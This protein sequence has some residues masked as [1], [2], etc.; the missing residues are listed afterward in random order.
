METTAL[1]DHLLTSIII[2]AMAANLKPKVKQ[3]QEH[4]IIGGEQKKHVKIKM[5]PT[6][7]KESSYVMPAKN[8]ITPVT[9][10]EKITKPKEPPIKPLDKT[11]V[12]LLSSKFFLPQVEDDIIDTPTRK[13]ER[14]SSKGDIVRGVKQKVSPTPPLVAAAQGNN[15]S[16]TAKASPSIEA[17]I[18]SPSKF[19]PA[20]VSIVD[21]N[22]SSS[23]LATAFKDIDNEIIKKQ[24]IEFGTLSFQEWIRKGVT[25]VDQQHE[26]IKD[27]VIARSKF[28]AKFKPI[29]NLVNDYGESLEVKDQQIRAKFEKLQELGKAMKDYIID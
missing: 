24:C 15:N 17:D 2:S 25:L 20:N 6:I 7:M 16:K 3:E 10:I 1:L 22:K 27:A 8:K 26:L 29:F 19:I 11:Q 9:P 5:E 12:D 4:K 13:R 21:S 18:K 23:I 28:N 14:P